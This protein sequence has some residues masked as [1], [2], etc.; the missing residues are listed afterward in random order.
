MA[1]TITV[2]PRVA[3]TAAA[4]VIGLG[5]GLVLVTVLRTSITD[6]E[7]YFYRYGRRVLFTGSFNRPS[8]MDNS[9]LPVSALNAVP[10]WAAAHVVI[11]TAGLHDLLQRSFGER[12]ASYIRQHAEL[13][14]G[15]LVTLGFY[16]A[17]CWLVF[18]WGCEIYGAAGG[19]A[20]TMLVALLPT[21]LGHAGLVT[22]DVAATCTI[23]A[24]VYAVARCCA[25]PSF[26]AALMAGAAFGLAQLV[27]YTALQLI[28]I[29]M[30]I[31]LVSVLAA[32]AGARWQRLRRGGVVLGIAAVVALAVI[33]LGFAFDGTGVR[34]VELS[35]RSSA[36]QS[37]RGLVGHAPLPLPREYLNGLDQVSF[38]DQTGIGGGAV[39][40]LGDLSRNGFASYYAIATVLKT[41]LPFLAL[42]LLR[43]WRRR[44]VREDVVLL[45][46]V[47]FL[48]VHLSFFFRTQLG[49]RYFLPAFPFLALLAAGNWGGGRGPRLQWLCSGLL[50]LY[51]LLSVLQCPRYLSYF[52]A[53]IGAPR[54]A[55]RYLADSNLD[56]GQDQFALWAWQRAHG[57]EPAA[58]ETGL[59]VIRAND[60]T[61]IND[62]EAYAWLRGRAAP[63]DTVGDSYL[64]FQLGE[65]GRRDLVQHGLEFAERGNLEAAKELDVAALQSDPTDTAARL[66]LGGVLE[67]QGDV[68]G[69]VIQYRE[70]IRLEP[71]SAMAHTDLAIALGSSGES[72]EAI[73]HCVTAVQ[74]EPERAELH[75]NLAAIL[76]SAGRL[77]EAV[78]QYRAALELKPDLTEAQRGLAMAL[79][80]NP[81]REHAGDP[82]GGRTP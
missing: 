2:N 52:N 22:V 16:V 11:P 45:V 27:K 33:N 81:I 21:L 50:G 57:G 53:L 38:D 62:S 82:N 41:P 73:A 29:A 1:R 7:P 77:P 36:C 12:E 76:A 47:L 60:F 30:V 40:L 61:G 66:A 51:V 4:C 17:L 23:F 74:L 56:W 3:A 6:D 24:A 78:E 69:A 63:V 79:A 14:A 49:L 67:S 75:Y 20:A 55:Y 44:R 58:R 5:V 71:D 65:N 46:P 70:A 54:N 35:C 48:F 13:Y 59:V 43:P 19:L 68:P 39:Y 28:P 64:V 37:L 72:D 8:W 32:D 31:L 15:R 18:A 80:E 42:L 25:A 26:S 9:K 10:E 34:L